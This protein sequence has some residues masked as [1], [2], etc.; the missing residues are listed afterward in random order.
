MAC[1][2]S[3]PSASGM[4]LSSQVTEEIRTIL[5]APHPPR[6]ILGSPVYLNDQLLPDFYRDR[7]F[8]PAWIGD[9]GLTPTAW[10]LHRLFHQVGL[11]NANLGGPP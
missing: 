2:V 4:S 5:A 1:A 9:L 10:E 6:L 8:R 11:A 3:P 7:N